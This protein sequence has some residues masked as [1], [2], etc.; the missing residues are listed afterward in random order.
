MDTEKYLQL[1][2][3]NFKLWVESHYFKIALFNII[4]ILLVLLRS[5]GYFE[6]LFPLSINLIVF[7][8]LILAILLLSAGSKSMFIV[9]LIFWLIATLFKIVNIN[10]WAER[11][12]L[13]SYQALVVGMVLVI[14]K[15]KNLNLFKLFR[16]LIARQLKENE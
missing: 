10:V 16:K 13:Y 1:W 8:S 4:L 3:K 2:D 11:A 7:F 14:L 9:S 5:A 15:D 6:P 12:A